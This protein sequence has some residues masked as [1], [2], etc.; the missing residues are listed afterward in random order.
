MFLLKWRLYSSPVSIDFHL[1]EKDNDS[2]ILMPTSD[3]SDMSVVI[4]NITVVTIGHF[5]NYLD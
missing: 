3:M 2:V 1:P 5:E 4:S